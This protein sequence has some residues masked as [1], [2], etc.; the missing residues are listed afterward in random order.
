MLRLP[1]AAKMYALAATLLLPLAIGAYSS[2]SL[3]LADIRYAE[4]EIQAVG[5]SEL[6][7]PLLAQVQQLREAHH[8]A[9][10]GDAKAQATEA[11]IRHDLQSAMQALDERIRAGLNFSLY[12]QWRPAQQALT[13]LLK[14]PPSDQVQAS[15]ARHD[16][17]AQKLLELSQFNG[18]I[19]GMILDPQA[20][21]YQLVDLLV[22]VVPPLVDTVA[23]IQA[24]GDAMLA[25]ERASVSE[26]AGILGLAGDLRKQTDNLQWRLAALKR[27]GGHAPQ[28]LTRAQTDLR[29]WAE[30][31]K[32]TFE[33]DDLRAG[34][35]DFKEGGV[36]AL[37]HVQALHSDLAVQLADELALRKRQIYQDL[38]I[39][40]GAV[41]VGLMLLIYLLAAYTLTFGESIRVLKAWVAAVSAGDLSGDRKVE[42]KD[43]L[44][45]MGTAMEAMSHRLS[46]L[47]AD[48]RSSASMVDQTGQLVAQGSD[49]LATRTDAQAQSLRTSVVAITQLSAAVDHNASAAQHLDT[50]TDKLAAKAE[51]ANAS[52]TETV[53]AMQA[54]QQAAERV[55]KVIA[56]I[57]DVAFQTGML[58]LNA[59]VEAARAG[60]S[61]KGFAIVASEIRQLAKRCGES[62]EEIRQ[63]INATD[64]QATLSADKL[65]SATGALDAI[66]EGV[67]DVSLQLRAI[68]ASTTQQS[69]GLKE[70]MHSVGSLDSITSQ[71]AS[72]VEES[73]SASNALVS[74]ANHLRESVSTVKLRQGSADEALTM[75]HKAIAHIEAVGRTQAEADFHKKDGGFIDRDLY[76]F[77][78]NREGIFSANGAKPDLVGQH[79]SKIPG[80]DDHFSKRVWEKADAGGGWVL[81]E[82]TNPLTHVISPKE[83]YVSDVGDGYLVGCGIYRRA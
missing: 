57:D 43:E 73:T 66:F 35:L 76:I 41:S 82:V 64:E 78:M 17:A 15:R 58:S 8:Q 65:D 77:S 62:A 52:M 7:T 19:S 24:R 22:N 37:H 69:M 53:Q 6:I 60:E 25:V 2:T 3:K 83:S 46:D 61:G 27:A 68:S 42:G 71:N 30:H 12:P 70:V 9:L 63:L 51:E 21:T 23:S 72:L 79:C 59:A 31:T 10:L 45:D 55:V 54:M 13:D 36:R 33:Q 32:V 75:V 38:A 4:T 39:E 40:A 18:E 1:M 44:A 74:R 26:R 50:L 34:H 48:I 67:R 47:V 49:K 14:S 5:V 28:H 56:V 81:Y 80:L 29:R 20:H 11:D 16:L